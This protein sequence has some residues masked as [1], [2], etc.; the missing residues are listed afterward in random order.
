MF[1]QVG[2]SKNLAQKALVTLV[3]EQTILELDGTSL[4]DKLVE[5]LFK[6]HKANVPD[7]YEHPEYLNEALKEMFGDAYKPV[8]E[9]IK[10][11]LDEFLEDKQISNFIVKISV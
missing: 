10:K 7:C 6:K 8:I 1:P 9:K 4:Y 5:I 3:I 2:I 11:E